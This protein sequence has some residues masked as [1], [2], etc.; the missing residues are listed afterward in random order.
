MDVIGGTNKPIANRT[1]T[2]PANGKFFA[3][4]GDRLMCGAVSSEMPHLVNP[5]DGSKF[6][7]LTH[8]FIKL[9]GSQL[10]LNF[11][12]PTLVL[13]KLG[14]PRPED[15]RQKTAAAF[16]KMIAQNRYHGDVSQSCWFTY[17][18]QANPGLRGSAA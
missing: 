13:Q 14:E 11:L 12:K 16:I 3:T 8:Y 1:L 15:E 4:D 9:V 7:R 18:L 17:E 10:D 2:N 6:S 5:A